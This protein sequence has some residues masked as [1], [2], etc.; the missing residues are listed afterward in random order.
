MTTFAVMLA[1]AAIAWLALPGFFAW[2]DKLDRRGQMRAGWC[3]GI[4]VAVLAVAGAALIAV[5]A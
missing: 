1:W 2:S 5:T 3:F 4:G